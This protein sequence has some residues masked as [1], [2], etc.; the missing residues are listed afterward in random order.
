MMR[1]GDR[2][3]RL[4]YLQHELFEDPAN[5]L[6]WAENKG[7]KLSKTMVF[8]EEKYPSSSSFDWLVIMGGSMGV[9]DESDYPWLIKEKRFI[10]EAIKNGRRVVG[11][12]L[13]AQL[14]SHVLGGGVRKND[15]TEI[16]W[17][18]VRLTPSAASSKAFEG[19]QNEFI[20]F[21]W[22]GDTFEIP[23]SAIHLAESDACMNQ[24]FEYAD[25]TVVGLQFH[26]EVDKRCLT[27]MA[28][29]LNK[30]KVTGRYV[31]NPSELMVSDRILNNIRVLLNRMLDNIQHR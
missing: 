21:H 17:Y 20:A 9:H 25:G 28:E 7:F 26:I 13:G 15:S 16:G 2:T 3:V 23:K 4:H 5:I 8:K 27:G 11:I 10:E 6:V 12:C 30:H 22:H 29:Y 31:Q 1:G 19:F 14:I 18:P 24:A